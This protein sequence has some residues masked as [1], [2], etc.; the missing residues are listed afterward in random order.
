MKAILLALAITTAAA[1]AEVQPPINVNKLADAIY[2]AEGG[3]KTRHPY[4][5]LSIKTANPRR[6]CINTINN[7]IKAWD[8]RSDFITFLALKYCPPSADPVGHRNWI[9]NVHYHYTR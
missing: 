8:G 5:V 2:L 7:R 3:R 1:S 9:K 6:I 4:G